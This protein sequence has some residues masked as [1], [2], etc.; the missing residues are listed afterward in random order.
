MN[1]ALF[2]PRPGVR[3]GPYPERVHEREPG[4]SY[5]AELVRARLLSVRTPTTGDQRR[6]LQMVHD[7]CEKMAGCDNQFVVVGIRRLRAKLA[8]EGMC[9]E[10]VAEV[11][12]LINMTVQKQLNRSLYDQ[13]FL[14][15][16]LMLD[17]RLIEMQ[18]GEG[19]TLAIA[20]AAATCALAGMPVHVVTSNDY[21]VARD[22]THLE[23]LF[24]A[25]GLTVGIVTAKASSSERMQAY[26]CDIV[27]CTAQE[28]VFD[29]LRD[30][31]AAAPANYG[32]G[33]DHAR[34]E[35]KLRGLCMAIVDEADSVLI[36]EART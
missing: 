14:A 15:A 32:I 1:N 8:V 5:L 24:H 4:T 3:H 25:L 21:L 29:Y 35:R 9:K 19:K 23:P 28:L 36:D 31:L 6:F 20:V 18:T 12:A 16:W 10:L 2:I 7:R 27:Y 33:I 26:R 13:Q 34:Q 11:F 22:A 30:H 17:R